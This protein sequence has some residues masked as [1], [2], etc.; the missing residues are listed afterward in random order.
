VSVQAPLSD[1]K[2]FLL[3]EIKIIRKVSKKN[4]RTNGKG[5]ENFYRFS[6]AK[7]YDMTSLFAKM[8]KKT[9]KF[10]TSRKTPNIL[11]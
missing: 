1:K 3:E 6:A 4:A 10:L 11:V 8:R 5:R 9:Q 2:V 7:F